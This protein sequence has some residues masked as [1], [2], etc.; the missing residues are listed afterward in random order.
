MPT[1]FQG[2]GATFC[3]Q[4]DYQ[5]D[6][7]YITTEFIIFA[8]I[9]I[10]PLKSVRVRYGGATGI[11]FPVVHSEERYAVLATTR[12]NIKQVL[13]VYG[14]IAFM[15]CWVSAF[16]LG[17]RESRGKAGPDS[18]FGVV[19]AGFCPAI[20]CCRFE[21]RCEKEN[22]I[23]TRRSTEWRPGGAL[24][25]FG[26]RWRAAIGELN[27]RQEYESRSMATHGCDG[28]PM[29]FMLGVIRAGNALPAGCRVY[30]TSYHKVGFA[31]GLVVASGSDSLGLV[32]RSPHVSA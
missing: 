7:S 31:S 18:G 10:M 17:L 23:P 24:W 20:T 12:P 4:R 25:Q 2:I 5:P 16:V 22:Q 1:S 28:D 8:G 32:F 26:S 30:V 15:I 9:P 6:G 13:S 21:A 29:L 11:V 14:F 27:V 19:F 3:G